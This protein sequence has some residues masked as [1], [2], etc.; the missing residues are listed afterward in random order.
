MFSSETQSMLYRTRRVATNL[1]EELGL[2]AWA[3]GMFI[4]DEIAGSMSSW[5]AA[6]ASVVSIIKI[7]FFILVVP[8]LNAVVYFV[9]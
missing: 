3:E 5:D 2:A 9:N 8:R 1:P 7:E 4:T 6:S